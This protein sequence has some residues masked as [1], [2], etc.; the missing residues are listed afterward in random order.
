MFGNY[1][2]WININGVLLSSFALHCSMAS[3]PFNGS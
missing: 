2:E 3:L 1:L